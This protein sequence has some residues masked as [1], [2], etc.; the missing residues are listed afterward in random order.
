M[1][2]RKCILQASLILMLMLLGCKK[3]ELPETPK[4]VTLQFSLEAGFPGKDQLSKLVII[5][6]ARDPQAQVVFNAGA[7]QTGT[8]AGLPVNW[9]YRDYDNDQALEQVI[10]INGNPFGARP[11]FTVHV[12]PQVVIAT[13]MKVTVIAQSA[14]G[15]EL[16]WGFACDNQDQDLFL[17][18]EQVV[19]IVLKSV[20]RDPCPPC[21][22]LACNELGNCPVDYTCAGECCDCKVP[23]E[24][25]GGL[26]SGNKTCL[27]GCCVIGGKGL[28]V[29]CTGNS[30]CAS[31]FCKDGVCCNTE[32]NGPCLNCATGSCTAVKSGQDAPECGGDNTCSAAGVCLLKDGQ[33]CTGSEACA[34]GFCKDGKCCNS[35]CTA[36]CHSCTTGVCL[37]VSSQEDYPECSAGNTCDLNGACKTKNGQG[38]LAAAECASGFCADGVCCD[39]ACGGTCVS[40]ATG[41]CLTVKNSD[42][43]PGCTGADT[44]DGQGACKKKQGQ[45]C[46]GAGECASGF[47]ADGKCC[48]TACTTACRSC[49]TGTC[50]IVLSGEDNPECQGTRMCDAAGLC[51]LENGQ[52]CASSSDCLSG[53]CSGGTCCDRDCPETCF[54][55]ATGQ[56]LQLPA[57]QPDAPHCTGTKVC[58]AGGACLF[59]NGEGCTGPSQCA[60]GYCKDGKCC[61]T[62]CTAPCHSCSSG[63]CQQVGT[64]G[65]DYPECIGSYACSAGA[66]CLFKNGLDCTGPSQCASGNCVDGKCCDTACVT[67]CHACNLAGLE[68]VC[69]Q[70]PAGSEDRPNCTGTQACGASGACLLKK[71]EACSGAGEACASGFCVDGKCCESACGTPCHNCATGACLPMGASQADPPQCEG[72]YACSA[73]AACLLKQGETCTASESCAS[74]HCADGR[75]CDTACTAV[76]YACNLANQE[77]TCSP[78]HQGQDDAPI[79]AGIFTCSP[80]S[81]CLL[82]NGQ[83]CSSATQCAS[84]SCADGK[85][86][87]T[88]CTTVCHACNLAGKEGS[89]SQ[90]PA[91]EADH[92]QCIGAYACNAQ[93]ECHFKN[94]EVCSQDGQCASGICSDGRCCNERCDASCMGCAT[95]TCAKITSAD[96]Y[97]QCTGNHTCDGGG[98]C[99]L[100]AVDVVAEGD[101]SCALLRDGTMKCWGDNDYGQLGNGATEKGFRPA[102]VSGLSQVQKITLGRWHACALLADRKVRCWGVNSSGQLGIGNASGPTI[103]E[104]ADRNAS[105]CSLLPLP[106][107]GLE[108]VIDVDAGSSH[109]CAVVTG[110]KVKCWGQGQYGLLGRPQEVLPDKCE[111]PSSPGYYCSH[112]PIEVPGITN[113]L[114]VSAGYLHT[115]A[116]LADGTI[117]CWG[118]N[119]YGQL[120]D[121]TTG[122]ISGSPPVA[123]GGISNALSIHTGSIHTCAVLANG[124]VK[125]WG[126]NDYG[127]LGQGTS[128][129]PQTCFGRGCSSTPLTVPGLTGVTDLASSSDRTCAVLSDGIVKCWG[130]AFNY[131]LGSGLYGRQPTPAA[132]VGLANARTVGV[133]AYHACAAL[134]DDTIK[135]WGG[136]FD[137]QMGIGVMGNWVVPHFSA[138]TSPLPAKL[139]AGFQ[140]SFALLDDGTMKSWGAN[141]EGQLGLG[142]WNTTGQFVPVQAPSISEAASVVAGSQHG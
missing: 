74:G 141:N 29:A 123:V 81:T 66:A 28:G 25:D 75:C 104:P 121:G 91:G 63:S 86:C 6:D 90:V 110:G 49:A 79:C 26:C 136:N 15:Q 76:C 48:D 116:V 83:A 129:G 22:H 44:C 3:T 20:R 8:I 128:E 40:C 124:T 85:C 68:G 98:I 38:C 43:P 53:S 102:T 87:D 119:G 73:Q 95:G 82:R 51:K 107:N 96:D 17:G 132:V 109:T 39:A 14:G 46:T 62:D 131:G 47:C 13:P 33:A 120:G 30:E 142:T 18:V 58:S 93:A 19:G 115:C 56:C 7:P 55:C 114:R 134:S 88:A 94:G 42:D 69:S 99:A 35:S 24:A 23:C 137:G 12:L 139:A 89:C 140:Q 34:S 4:V 72:N 101:Y 126:K 71:G 60:S 11:F 122:G 10:T 54:S 138:T 65:E 111:H 36:P 113:A 52:G 1:N 135:C 21:K 92:P 100:K 61:D 103:C 106:V 125:C 77:G 9:E 16:G 130:D 67:D 64:G 127:Q 50:A 37:K 117:R 112:N 70:L 105:P 2:S 97:P 59:K 41:A 31:S 118:W 108:G 133:G 84:E 45:P 32:C 5:L 78:V 57:G 27:N 80:R